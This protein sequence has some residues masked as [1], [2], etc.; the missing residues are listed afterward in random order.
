MHRSRIQLVRLLHKLSNIFDAIILPSDA[1]SNSSYP[2]LAYY[3]I[4]VPVVK[5]RI[6]LSLVCHIRK[7]ESI[8]AMQR[9]IARL[10]STA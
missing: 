4:K 2:T 9:L 3:Y 5:R 10:D 8:G 6:C 7:T 1:A